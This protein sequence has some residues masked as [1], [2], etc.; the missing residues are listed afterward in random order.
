MFGTA[1]RGG[2][3][4]TDEQDW[5]PPQQPRPQ[6]ANGRPA[7]LPPATSHAP[8]SVAVHSETDDGRPGT[9]LAGRRRG[10]EANSPSTSSGDPDSMSRHDA[11]PSPAPRNAICATNIPQQVDYTK[12]TMDA[13]HSSQHMSEAIRD[14]T[15]TVE[16]AVSFR[17]RRQTCVVVEFGEDVMAEAA[18]DYLSANGAGDLH[19]SAWTGAVPGPAKG[20]GGHRVKPQPQRQP[21]ATLTLLRD[22]CEDGMHTHCR[23]GSRRQDNHD[24]RTGMRDRRSAGGRGGRGGGE[25]VRGGG[26]DGGRGGGERGGGQGPPRQRQQGGWGGSRVGPRNRGH[27]PTD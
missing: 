18:L 14:G 6:P 5:L 7:A 10:S 3:W 27:F 25:G 22:D 12:Y 9:G 2:D 21:K 20:G 24:P 19:W 23:D 8:P 17:W 15:I 1:G 11:E 13:I 26:G 4:R 16:R